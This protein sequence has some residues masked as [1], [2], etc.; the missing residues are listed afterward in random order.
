[1]IFRVVHEI[2]GTFSLGLII[3]GIM[4][5]A[6]TLLQRGVDLIA[7]PILL[8]AAAVAPLDIGVVLMIVGVILMVIRSIIFAIFD[9]IHYLRKKPRIDCKGHSQE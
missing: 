9:I 5:S 2:F 8:V 3:A 4:L 6:A 7:G 1:M